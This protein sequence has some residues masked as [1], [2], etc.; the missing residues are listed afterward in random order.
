MVGSV[1]IPVPGTPVI[2]AATAVTTTIATA[3]AFVTA[4]TAATRATTI[5]TATAAIAAAAVEAATAAR[6]LA[7]IGLLYHQR[8]LTERNIVQVLNGIAAILFVHHFH[9]CKATA[10]ACFFVHGYFS[11][12]DRAKF[13]ENFYQLVVKQI[14]RKAGYKKFHTES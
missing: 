5:A 3:T 1:T 2:T 12:R 13:F 8:L 10:F 11:R 7:L 9:K 4:A 14:V 6:T